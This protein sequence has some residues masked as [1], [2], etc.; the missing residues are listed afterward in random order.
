MFA[1][2]GHPK[3]WT[4]TLFWRFLPLPSTGSSLSMLPFF[5][6]LALQITD[7]K[8]EARDHSVRIP[9]TNPTMDTKVTPSQIPLIII[10][11][12][13]DVLTIF[14]PFV[15]RLSALL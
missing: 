8:R 14:N 13:Q 1:S 2:G 11:S 6:R 5:D 4:C 10:E 12:H 15:E 7:L 3:E 9:I